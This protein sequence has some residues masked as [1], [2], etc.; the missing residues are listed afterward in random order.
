MNPPASL[1]VRVH[2][3]TRQRCGDVIN[4][5][6]CRVMRIPISKNL[7]FGVVGTPINESACVP[8]GARSSKYPSALWGRYQQKYL[9]A[10]W[11][12]LFT[13]CPS[14]LWGRLHK[15]HLSVLALSACLR[16]FVASWGRPRKQYAQ[17]TAPRKNRYQSNTPEN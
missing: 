8:V 7:A 15:Y 16:M 11:S 6:T 12:S 13:K 14:A 5:N 9:E 3:N 4:K 17:P 2:Q 1:W 10:L